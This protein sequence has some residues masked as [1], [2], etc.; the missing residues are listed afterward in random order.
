MMKKPPEDLIKAYGEN[1]YWWGEIN[2]WMHRDKENFTYAAKKFRESTD[3]LQR[4]KKKHNHERLK[5]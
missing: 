4:I 1:A 3:N 2:Y 5:R